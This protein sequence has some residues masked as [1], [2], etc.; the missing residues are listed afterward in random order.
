MVPKSTHVSIHRS[1][2]GS[3]QCELVASL[4]V[5]FVLRL[6]MLEGVVSVGYML[7]NYVCRWARRMND[8]GGKFLALAGAA[9]P[10]RLRIVEGAASR[11]SRDPGDSRIRF[12]FFCLFGSGKKSPAGNSAGSQ[13]NSWGK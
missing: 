6:L 13:K 11:N 8:I 1:L 3:I 5:P 7:T 12:L 4:A 9:A 2:L 10:R